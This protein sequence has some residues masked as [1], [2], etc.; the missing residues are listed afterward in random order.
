MGELTWRGDEVDENVAQ[1]LEHPWPE[2]PMN[3]F[4]L[5]LGLLPHGTVYLVCPEHDAATRR[6]REIHKHAEPRIWV[7][8][9]N[10]AVCSADRTC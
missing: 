5:R 10:G 8:G 6:R 7:I 3:A 1:W 4:G 9:N 2:H